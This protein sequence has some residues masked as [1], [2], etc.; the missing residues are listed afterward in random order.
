MGLPKGLEGLSEGFEGL[1]EGPEGLPEGPKGLPEGPEGL[2]EGPK[3]LPGGLGGWT[4][5]RTY[6]RT[7]ERTDGQNF[8][9]FYRNSSPVGA[10]AQKSKTF[11]AL[12]ELM[13]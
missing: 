13:F 5:G 11:E 2:P 1:P 9:P 7:D 4:D 8:P 6:R 10:A 3:G 12:T